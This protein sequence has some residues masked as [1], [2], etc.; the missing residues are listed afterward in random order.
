M[1]L[2]RKLPVTIE[3][4]EFEGFDKPITMDGVI[5]QAG[6]SRYSME[7]THCSKC[8]K[9]FSKHGSVK[10]LE[11]NHIVCPGDMIIKGI[12][13]EFYPVKSDIFEATYEVV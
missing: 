13:G 6:V 5:S 9:A 3:A 7:T 1:A 4:E 8:D 12:A 10:T 2:Y 11:G